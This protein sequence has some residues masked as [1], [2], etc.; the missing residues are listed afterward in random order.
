M[1][2]NM[3]LERPAFGYF[4]Q[5]KVHNTK[6]PKPKIDAPT[7]DDVATPKLPDDAPLPPPAYGSRYWF[8]W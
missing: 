8:K 6:R 4:C 2:D 3:N 5:A 1:L 7:F